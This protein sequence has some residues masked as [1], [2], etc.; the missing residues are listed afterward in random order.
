MNVEEP[1]STNVTSE[2]PSQNEESQDQSKVEQPIS[3]EPATTVNVKTTDANV[4]NEKGILNM[5][6]VV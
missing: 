5:Q 3:T 6:V 4:N 1:N 2:P